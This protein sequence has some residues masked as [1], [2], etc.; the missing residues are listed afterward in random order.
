[1][2]IHWEVNSI[3]GGTDCLNPGKTMNEIDEESEF[4]FDSG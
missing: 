3:S 4:R 2:A 1:M